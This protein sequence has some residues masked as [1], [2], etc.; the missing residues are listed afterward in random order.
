M[1]QGEV[2]HS[3]HWLGR[4]MTRSALD[5][6]KANM[7]GFSPAGSCPGPSLW[8]QRRLVRPKTWDEPVGLY[9]ATQPRAASSMRSVLLVAQHPDI[10]ARNNN[11]EPSSQPAG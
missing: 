6:M 2:G 4:Y 3:K 11:R 5:H 7:L 10:C 8:Q 9:I 1:W